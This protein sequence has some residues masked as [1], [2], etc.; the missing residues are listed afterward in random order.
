[1]ARA[2]RAASER[3][4]PSPERWL[5]SLEAD[6]AEF[7][8]ALRWARARDRGDIALALGGALSWFW[9]TRGHLAEGVEWLRWAVDHAP[10]ADPETRARALRGTGI[11]TWL[12]GDA[13][14]A[15]PLVDEAV[16][17]FR[18][19]GNEEEASGCVCASAFHVCENPI[20]SLPVV[21][22]DVIR[23]RGL[24][25]T[26]RLARSLGNAGVAYFFV[27][28]A[29][30]AKACFEECL[31]LPRDSVEL[32]VVAD[33][34]LGLGRVSVLLGDLDA[35]EALFMESIELTEPSGDHDGHSAALVWIGEIHRIRGDYTAARAVIERAADL[36]DNAGLPMSLARCHQFLGRLE[37]SEGN[38]DRARRLLKRSLKAPGAAQM[39]YHRIRSLQALADVALIDGTTAGVPKLL[40]EALSLARATGDRQ[41]Q[42]LVLTSLARLGALERDPERASRFAHE[43]LQVQERIGD[44][45]GI[46]ASLETLAELGAASGRSKVAARLYGAAQ[47]AR[48]AR[49]C[50]RALVDEPAR[51]QRLPQVAALLHS[52]AWAAAVSEGSQLSTPDAVSY[53]VKGR[54]SKDRPAIGW[55]S[56]TRAERDIANLVA[57]GMSN[58][59]IG[60]R[61]LVSARTVETHLSHIYR[62]V[63]LAN[64]RELGRAARERKL[65]E[66]PVSF[67][68]HPLGTS[69]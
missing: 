44:V 43:G 47:K 34:L 16:D 55:D 54:G 2:E 69:P 46:I 62:K 18:E 7:R 5:D 6:H 30:R 13:A 68:T 67:Q 12:L 33:A 3:V 38:L 10:D 25:D 21:E 29:G 15:L 32:E 26:G 35:A 53:A 60:L 61:L 11:L 52:G 50:R 59:E 40:D 28:D 58:R 48:E 24:E 9:E 37:A 56:L 22:A 65:A 49:G 42:G 23:I 45:F 8:G 57:D 41:A 19:A 63:P 17:L 27:S 20:H 31:A 64:R 66:Q 1:V 39:S 51:A 36:A 4:G 14:T